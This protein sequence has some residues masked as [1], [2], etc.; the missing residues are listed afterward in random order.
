MINI[1]ARDSLIEEIRRVVREEIAAAE[2]LTY[3]PRIAPTN[4]V[5]GYCGRSPTSEDDGA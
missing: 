4:A 2:R 3:P 5:P 1:S